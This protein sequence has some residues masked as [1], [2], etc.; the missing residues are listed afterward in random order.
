MKPILCPPFAALEYARPDFAA[1]QAALDENT[2]RVQAA[3][4]AEELLAV[5][6]ENDAMMQQ[7][8]FQ[9]GL[10][11][12]RSY[13]DSSDPFYAAELQACS[14]G[15]ARLDDT[16]IE[17]AVLASP[18][19][20]ALDERFGPCY[21]RRKQ[22]RVRLYAHGH[23]LQA[24]EQELT[25]RYQMLKATL[26]IPF[27]GADR[28]E[29]EMTRYLTS[30]DRAV[31][32][33]AYEARQQAFL[34]HKEEL[35]TLLDELVKNRV[36]LARANGFD[37][38][39][40]YINLEK[41][42]HGYGQAE[43]LAFCAQVRQDLVP[44]VRQLNEA[45]ARRLGLERLCAY[46]MNLTFADGAP[47]PIG[48]GP[49][50]L[51][52]GKAMY[53]AMDPEIAAL[54]R[55]M[56]DNGYIDVSQSPHKIAGMGFCEALAPLKLPYIFGNCDG[57]MHD[58]TVLTHEMGHAYQ[59]W[60]CMR[61]QP[62]PEY[63]DMPNDVVEI[64]SKAM[65]QFTS[66]YA[67][68]FFGADAAKFRYDHLKYVANEICSFCAT[69]EYED[70]LYANPD[71][72][73][74]Q[75]IDTF[76]AVFAAYGGGVDYSETAALDG[77]GA[78]LYRSIGVYMFPGYL[79]SYALS[80]MGA[81]EFRARWEA[82]PA[83]ALADYRTLCGLGGSLDYDGLLAA[84]HLHTAYAPGAAARAAQTLAAALAE[85]EKAL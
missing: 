30:P 42:R 4:T 7:A 74:Q 84:A 64:P 53:D 71:A 75:R 40:D 43:L 47:K 55:A 22:T 38:F 10:A 18:F 67:E 3:R 58:T 32:K 54:Y 6:V 28:S 8:N 9:S 48:D 39:V 25:N 85:C 68:R 21:L 59:M 14:Q 13:L 82:D 77:A 36:A 41:G 31:R 56:A 2:R 63:Y 80:D 60:R 70:W 61:E 29:G 66:P 73:A 79:I 44:L 1:L 11:M 19:A 37:R 12:I 35:D 24:K 50:L 57:S 72:S 16:A 15:M 65:E 78:Q 20:A 52:A 34:A 69:H 45:Q 5:L 46:D 83:A 51:E 76:N 23:E 27:D 81:L 33:A 26:R 49:A 17:A 62:V